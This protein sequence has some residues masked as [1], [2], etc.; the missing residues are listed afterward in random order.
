M[1]FLVYQK[2]K[3]DYRDDPDMIVH[4]FEDRLEL[5]KWALD[6]GIRLYPKEKVKI[7][8]GNTGEEER[9]TNDVRSEIARLEAEL[10]KE[11]V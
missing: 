4:S 8:N 6:N 11:E 7:L 5:C 9:G 10:V 1:Y 2:K 3:N